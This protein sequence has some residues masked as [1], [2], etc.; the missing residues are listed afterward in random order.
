MRSLAIQN[1][2]RVIAKQC[3]QRLSQ[4]EA[5]QGAAEQC[6]SAGAVMGSDEAQLGNT[7]E[8]MIA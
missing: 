5:E 1:R 6:A 2:S 7:V 4:C 3:S 8:A